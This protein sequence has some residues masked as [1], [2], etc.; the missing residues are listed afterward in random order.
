[1]KSFDIKRVDG[2]HNISI[3]GLTAYEVECVLSIVLKGSR[4]DEVGTVIKKD[5]T[6]FKRAPNKTLRRFSAEQVRAMRKMRNEDKAT[7][8]AVG[9]LYG[10][11]ELSARQICQG[12]TYKD[13]V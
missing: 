9:M 8:K 7:Y 3:Q 2:M 12:N 11:T 5:G 4:P 10:V 13:V 6:E 1:M